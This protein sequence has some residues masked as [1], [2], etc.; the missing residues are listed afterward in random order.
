MR[1]ETILLLGWKRTQKDEYLPSL[2]E[3]GQVAEVETLV[4]AE[5]LLADQPPTLLL[6]HMPLALH[7]QSVFK[8][9]QHQPH[10]PAS[11]FLLEHNKPQQA[12]EAIQLG[13][14]D[15][16]RLPVSPKELKNRVQWLVDRR[17]RESLGKPNVSGRG[18][19]SDIGT[20]ELIEL[21]ARGHG[22]ATVLVQTQT[23]RAKLYFQNGLLVGATLNHRNGIDALSRLLSWSQGS[24]E[25]IPTLPPLDEDSS[26]LA[27]MPDPLTT[28]LRIQ[29]EW[30]A[31]LQKLPPL[32]QSIQVDF[33]RVQNNLDKLSSLAEQLLWQ[34]AAHRSLETLLDAFDGELSLALQEL[35]L[36]FEQKY[37]YPS[38]PEPQGSQAHLKDVVGFGENAASLE[39]MSRPQDG[40]E[41][42]S[43]EFRNGLALAA[44]EAAAHLKAAALISTVAPNSIDRDKY[45][46]FM[47][48]PLPQTDSQGR[49]EASWSKSVSQALDSIFTTSTDSH[50]QI[51]T[52]QLQHT[53]TTLSDTE[54]VPSFEMDDFKSMDDNPSLPTEGFDDWSLTS[55]LNVAQQQ[56]PIITHTDLTATGP[57]SPHDLLESSPSLHAAQSLTEATPAQPNK[58]PEGIHQTLSIGSPPLTEPETPLLSLPTG[59]FD[60]FIDRRS[61]TAIP[62]DGSIKP[63]SPQE[64]LRAKSPLSF[65]G[66]SSDQAGLMEPLGEANTVSEDDLPFT[67]GPKEDNDELKQLLRAET[68]DILGKIVKNELSLGPMTSTPMSGSASSVQTTTAPSASPGL[69]LALGPAVPSRDQLPAAPG[70]T[71][72][73]G[74]AVSSRDQLPS[75]SVPHERFTPSVSELES[76]KEPLKPVTSFTLEF[77][78]PP[79]SPQLTAA[80]S[81]ALEPAPQKSSFPTR[82]DSLSPF[83]LALEQP[84]SSATEP[85]PP[86]SS[87]R[88]R[89]PPS[90]EIPAPTD[91]DDHHIGIHT[92]RSHDELRL[93]DE[94]FLHDDELNPKKRNRLRS[95]LVWSGVSILFAGLGFLAMAGYAR[96]QQNK[97]ELSSAHKT[98]P[99]TQT[100]RDIP[101]EQ[102]RVTPQPERR[103]VVVSSTPERPVG[104]PEQPPVRPG[105][106]VVPD[107]TVPSETT[108]PKTQETTTPEDTR[109][110]PVLPSTPTRRVEPTPERQD[111]RPQ[112]VAERPQPRRE[113]T[114]E[115]E[116]PRIRVVRRQRPPVRVRRSQ[117]SEPPSGRN[118]AQVSRLY[119]QA[120]TMKKRENFRAAESLLRQALRLRPRNPA[121]MYSLLGQVLYE[122]EQTGSAIRFLERAYRMS[123]KDTGDGLVT[124]GSIYY[125]KGKRTQAR[126]IY[127]QYLKYFPKGRHVNDVKAM[128]RN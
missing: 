68:L 1:Q 90:L 44:Q 66:T 128:L 107:R 70:L 123:P 13:A 19:L 106:P 114:S 7:T 30:E 95:F 38:V 33:Q 88:A 52:P 101:R 71:L 3:F 10:R 121:P 4:E 115:P 46:S 35:T 126:Q 12:T 117:E 89:R 57:Q 47:E 42:P 51:S 97:K 85:T 82:T 69:T 29:S 72:A 122:R 56:R 64:A 8:K 79:S 94:F 28:A 111:S 93:S 49:M 6:A 77:D 65:D 80:P 36:L 15:V 78:A 103:V 119:Q 20:R 9:L 113:S 74:P 27:T 5:R 40:L 105:T 110:P 86:Q 108:T 92:R 14:D 84:V 73:L 18:Q 34:L 2:R 100:Q 11:L 22:S 60:R 116:Q 87:T 54:A 118:Q 63:L 109:T 91:K 41:S 112:P 53:Q 99:S 120:Q 81:L 43:M 98:T 37:F 32:S 55:H 58:T 50:L 104:G 67:S 76:V 62:D 16:L 83:H 96:F 39:T 45:P 17:Q 31:C 61:H 21:F 124:L 48:L 102:P 127:Q 75:A 26:S 23:H 59:E 25:I 125:E 24:F